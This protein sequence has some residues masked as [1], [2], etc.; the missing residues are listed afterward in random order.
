[1]TKQPR[2]WLKNFI[3]F[4]LF[5]LCFHIGILITYNGLLWQSEKYLKEHT[6]ETNLF[7]GK[8]NSDE[9]F[10][11]IPESNQSMILGENCDSEDCGTYVYSNENGV[12]NEPVVIV[13]VKGSP[14]EN[15]QPIALNLELKQPHTLV[16]VSEKIVGW[17]I[18]VEDFKYIKKVVAVAPKLVWINNLPENV[19]FEFLGDK[20]IC[21]HNWSGLEVHNS[22]NQFRKLLAALREHLKTNESLFVG[23]KYA[24]KMT[25]TEEMLQPHEVSRSVAQTN[26]QDLGSQGIKWTRLKQK[27][28]ASTFRYKEAGSDWKELSIPEDTRQA[29]R[30]DGGNIMMLKGFQ[31]GIWNEKSKTFSAQKDSG[32]VEPIYWPTSIAWDE[33]QKSTFLFN[34]ERGGEIYSFKD[35]KWQL[36]RS[37][38]NVS[39]SGLAVDAKNKWLYGIAVKGKKIAKILRFNMQGEI[40]AEYAVTSNIPY[41]E[42]TWRNQTEMVDSKLYFRIHNVAHPGGDLHE[43]L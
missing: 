11:P 18:K 13:S 23:K 26:L 2:S 3:Y 16:L 27:L 37:G 6:P 31:F 40:T 39:I 7:C 30:D 25:V 19:P 43:L 15:Y 10:W 41:D 1:M 8:F 24:D 34:N 32:M 42:N 17:N 9:A 35:N 38:L 5:F 12:T 33:V 22:D 21:D 4:Y 20:Q 28:R 29:F 36:I 14:T